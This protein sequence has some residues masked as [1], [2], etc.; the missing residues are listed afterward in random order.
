MNRTPSLRN[1][2]LIYHNSVELYVLKTYKFRIYPTKFQKTKMERTLDLCR[3]T[4]NQTLAYRKNAYEQ[5]SK[6]ISK[7]EINVLL[8]VWK[9]D[10]PEL[11]EV[12]AQTP[13]NVQE[14]VDLAF[15]AFFRRAKA[16]EEPGYPRFK[17]RGRYDSFTY[18]QPEKG[19]NLVNGMV[20]LPKVYQNLLINWL[21]LRRA[22][23]SM[24]KTRTTKT[25]TSTPLSRRR[26]SLFPRMINRQGRLSRGAGR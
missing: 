4:Y 9:R 6:S 1:K 11:G 3:W 5:E 25:F 12:Y 26:T 8:S 15:K 17:G 24:V 13:Q 21:I 18:P 14:R 7:Y 20:R 2:T 22:S 19:G 16:G 23:A 10:K